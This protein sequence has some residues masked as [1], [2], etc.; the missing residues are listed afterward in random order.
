MKRTVCLILCVLLILTGC[1][2]RQ[3][4]EGTAFYYHRT[5]TAFRGSDG[6]IAAEL[7]DVSRAGDDL[8]ALLA[9]YCA[10]PVSQGLENP[11]PP[12]TAV[13]S[14]SL[15]GGE[16]T[17]E[18]DPG[19][20]SLSGVDLTV[21]AGCL[22]K[23]FLELTGA[24]VLVL[25]AGGALLNGQTSLRLTPDD[26]Q[27]RDDSPDRLRQELTVYYTDG[28]R[29]YLLPQQVTL[30]P[31]TA[32]EL[33]IQLLELLQP[34]EDSGLRSALPSGT[35]FL[36]ATVSDGLCTVAVNPGFESIRFYTHSSQVLTIL[37]IVN[38]LTGLPQIDRV[39]LTVDGQLLTGYGPL[40]ITAPLV[41][42][43]RCIGPVRTGLGE[44][45]VTLYL[46][47]GGDGRLLGVP[48]RLPRSTTV[49]QAELIL[50]CLLRD[51]GTNGIGTHIPEGTALNA[52]RIEDGTCFV[53]LSREYL[54]SPSELA[55]SARVIAASLCTLEEVQQVQILVNGSVP[56]EFDSKLFGPLRP[57]GDWFL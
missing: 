21:A 8:T 25:T 36:S 52:L 18:F 46:A 45:D 14:H 1:V 10:G 35:R 38:T 13:L 17:L 33:P 20:A 32:E 4:E 47:H 48:N 19:L 53:D 30:S 56:A 3:P 6:V 37:A 41:R 22:A 50:R 29:R 31:G 5:D 28:E 26:L 23:T 51:S 27:L 24:D 15:T 39:E 49:S 34:P 9:L 7:R 40:S 43:E 12:G 11:L 54:G 2:S 44:Q 16:L 42:D 57:T 55:L